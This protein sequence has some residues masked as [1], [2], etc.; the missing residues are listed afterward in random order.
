MLICGCSLIPQAAQ[1]H[2]AALHKE[3]DKDGDGQVSVEELTLGS[4]RSHDKTIKQDR[5]KTVHSA[6]D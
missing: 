3:M 2:A 6:K 5:K 4:V 1:E